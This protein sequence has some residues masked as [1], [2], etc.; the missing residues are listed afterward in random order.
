MR[1]LRDQKS[2]PTEIEAT[3]GVETSAKGTMG[4]P[5]PQEVRQLE[6]TEG[7]VFWTVAW[8]GTAVSGGLFGVAMML[9]AAPSALPFFFVP[10][11]VGFF[12]A[13]FWAIPFLGTVAVVT[14]AF[15]LSRFR[16][17]AAAVAGGWTGV[18]ASCFVLGGLYSG[19]LGPG[20]TDSGGLNYGYVILAGV[21]GA[22]GCPLFIYWFGRKIF[23][24]NKKRGAS[25]APW[26]FTLRDL[27]VHFTVLAVL[28]S[29]WTCYFTIRRNI[30]L[31]NQQSIDVFKEEPELKEYSNSQD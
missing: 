30:E 9:M 12:V 17:L 22:V 16:M 6:F 8:L 5:S 2:N 28:I 19:P 14:W 21:F 31:K 29:L 7:L 10:L 3:I 23:F 26:Q 24:K 25:N 11:I 20:S 13:G 27:F 1:S 4:S 15:W 18:M